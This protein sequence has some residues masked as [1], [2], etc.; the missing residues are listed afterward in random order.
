MT[1]QI[2]PTLPVTGTPTTASVRGNFQTAHDEITALQSSVPVASS[3]LPTM[4]GAAA[5]GTGATYARADH[6]HPTDTTRYAASNPAGYQTA[7]QIAATYLPL[8]GGTLNGGLTVEEGVSVDGL[9]T[10]QS[11]INSGAEIIVGGTGIVYGAGNPGVFLTVT[12]GWPLGPIISASAAG[13][14]VSPVLIST[15]TTGAFTPTPNIALDGSTSTMYAWYGAA[16]SVTWNVLFS[17]RRLKTAIAPA[18]QDALAAIIALPV[19]EFDLSPPFDDAVT[20]HWNW[21]LMAD[22]V[23]AIPSA[24]VAAIEGGYA[25]L[26]ELPIVAALVRAVQQLTARVAALEPASLANTRE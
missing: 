17:D 10:A 26:R 2:D 11:G 13:Q 8:A 12:G 18:S 19:Y 22:E 14:T 24:S 1:S 7:A 25:S 16:E 9:I 20:Q 15:S 23:D 6:T 5:V 3:T 21:G 4:N